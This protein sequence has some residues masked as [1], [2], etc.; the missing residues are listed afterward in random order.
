MPGERIG[1]VDASD[2]NAVADI[3]ERLVKEH[4]LPPK[5][6]IVHRFTKGMVTN[7]KKIRT[8]PEVQIVMQMDGFGF[9]AKK[10]DSYRLT[11][12]NEPVQFAGF[13]L[14]YR[15]DIKE[16]PRKTIMTPQEVL[17]IYPRPVY[18]QYQ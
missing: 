7:Y 5:V 17:A 2:I 11:I 1:T 3:L 4:N 15:E 18:I 12:L 13:K 16:G 9:P 6:L 10:L 14:F 8:R